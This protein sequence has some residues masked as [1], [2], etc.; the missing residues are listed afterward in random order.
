MILRNR[1]ATFYRKSTSLHWVE[2]PTTE[3]NPQQ[4]SCACKEVPG[5]ADHPPGRR[6]CFVLSW[7]FTL[8]GGVNQAV[9]NL[10][11]QFGSGVPGF[12]PLALEL[13]WNAQHSEDVL[14]SGVKRIYL[15]AH[16]PY[17]PGKPVRAFLALLLRLPG[18]LLA[19]R[20]VAKQNNVAA[21]NIHFPDLEALTFVLLRVFR[22]FDGEIILSMHGSD[23][24][25]AH[26]Q[27]SFPKRMWR[28]ILRH[29]TVVVACSEGLREE[30]LLLEPRSRTTTIYNGV[31]VGL[32]AAESGSPFEWP[33]GLEGRRAIVNI[34]SFEYRK[35]HD[36][37]V[38]AFEHVVSTH[39]DTVL[40]L[41]GKRGPVSASVREM[42]RDRHLEE[43]IHIFEDVPHSQIY[44]LLSRATLFALAT[45][46]RKCEMGE[47]FAIA[48]LE[49]A[50]AKVPV[51]ATASCG[52]QEIIADGET[53]RMVPLEDARALA[54]AI[55]ELLDE[56]LA[57]RR[58]AENLHAL[59]RQRFT[60]QRAADEYARLCRTS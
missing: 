30:I 55:C 53:G 36:V 34:A 26:Q 21:F 38:Q 11:R 23:I 18:E 27:R 25:S 45:R 51:V 33:P 24:R 47:G 15:R 32:F 12:Q 1:R 16:A 6:F 22:L 58:M 19:V 5:A 14:P 31:N 43:S 37:L 29:A 59:V 10:I 41:V 28:F 7:P 44:S 50:A 4:S 2:A 3:L 57:A 8:Y 42:I 20:R 56:P 54:G 52:V 48:I 13:A 60:W 49:A 39:P 35:G 9:N 40:L 17:V 46:W